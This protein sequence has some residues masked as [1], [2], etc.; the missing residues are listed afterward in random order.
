MARTVYVPEAGGALNFADGTTDQQIVDYVR[1]KYAP[2]PAPAP[3]EA[4]IGAL[5]SGFYGSLG[6]VE[7]AGGKA[8]QGLGLDAL[9]SDLFDRARAN[10]EYA[11]K[12]VPDVANISDIQGVGDVA[13]FAGS[14]IAQSAP[15]TAL[16][17]AGA[18]A[19]AATGASIGTAF[20]PGPGTAVGGV[21]GGIIGGAIASLPSFVGG[22]V[23]AQ[24]REQGISLE[25]TSGYA[26]TVGAVAQAPLDAAFDTLIARKFPGAGAALDV[27][28]KGFFKEVANTAWKGAG[29]EALTEPAQQAIEIAQANPLKLLEFGPDVQNELLNA[30]AGGALAGGIIGGAAVP[31]SRAVEGYAAGKQQEQGKQIQRDYMADAMRG[32]QMK[33][34]AEINAGIESLSAQPIL[35]AL[36]LRKVRVEPTPANGLTD[37]IERFQISDPK[38]TTIAEFSDAVNAT[39]AVNQYSKIAGKKINL[40]NIDTGAR[41]PTSVAP[42]KPVAAD[43]QNINPVLEPGTIDV[44]PK[45]P[46]MPKA[47]ASAIK[48]ANLASKLQPID[49]AEIPYDS[50][51]WD[52][53]KKTR[54]P[55]S[56]KSKIIDYGGRK[57]VVVSVN[58]VKVPFYLSSGLAGKTNVPSGKWYP[59]FGIGTDGWINKTSQ[60]EIA[61]YYGDEDLRRVSETLDATVGDIRNDQT[62]PR[63]GLSGNHISFINSGLDPSENESPDTLEKVTRNIKST[64]DKVRANKPVPAPVEPAIET[65]SD[66]ASEAPIGSVEPTGLS[67]EPVVAIPEVQPQT[68]VAGTEVDLEAAAPVMNE[69]EQ[70]AVRKVVGER[71]QKITEGV[72]A[73]LARYNLKDVQTKF[74]PAFMD[75]M[76]RPKAQEGSE[77]ISGGKSIVTLATDIYDPSLTTEEMVSK[78]IDTLNHESIHS[79]FDLGLIRPSERQVLFNAVSNAKVPGKKYTYLDYAKLVY[80]PK[81]PGLEIYEN[82]EL[83]IEEAVAEMFRDWRNRGTGATAN[84]RGLF[85]RVI[86]ALRHMFNVMRRNNYEDI[87]TQV[88]KGEVGLR[89]R[90]TQERAD[91]QSS[92]RK[93]I[94]PEM[95]KLSVAP[96]YPY[97]QRVPQVNASDTNRVIEE[98]EY[99]AIVTKIDKIF[100]SRIFSYIP[101]RYKPSEDSITEFMQ[102]WADKILPVG[103]MIDFVKQNGGTVTDA[104]DTYQKAQLSVSITSENLGARETNLYKPL[105][106]FMKENGIS[107]GEIGRYVYAL[108]AEERN[109]RIRAITEPKLDDNGNPI[110]FDP[111]FGSGMSDADARKI[112]KD[113]ESGP[114]ASQLA[115]AEQMVRQI[116]D[117]TNQLRLDSGLSPDYETIPITIQTEDGRTVTLA[118]YKKYV[119]LRG[120]ADESALDGDMA[121]EFKARIG[122]GFK[123]KGREDMRAFGRT[124]EASYE[125]IL[126]HIVLQNKEA[127]VRAEKNKVGQS[128]L[129]LIETNPEILENYGVEIMTAKTKPMRKYVNSRGV[130]KTM[131]DPMYKNSNDVFVVKKDG[132]EIPIKIDNRLLQKALIV[133]KSIDPS[134]NGKFIQFLGKFNRIMAAANTVYNP[135]FALI[136]FPRDLQQ[137]MLNFTQYDI[138]GV[139]MKILKDAGPAAWNVWKILRDPK[140]QNDWSDVYAQFKSDGG[141]TS[142]FYGAFSLEE[143]IR[144]LERMS[145]DPSNSPA[146]RAKEAILWVGKYL[147]DYNGAFE[148][149]IRLSVYKNLLD[150]NV[151]RQKAAFIAKNITVNFDQ[152]GEN[153]P[154]MNSL[155]LFYNASVQ[156]TMTLLTAAARSKKVRK[157]LMGLVFFGFMQDLINSS[158]SQDGDDEEPLYDKLPDYKLEN[159]IILMDPFGFTDKGYI[160]IPLG[161]G[162]NA[163]VNLG[164]A[165]S[166]SIRGGYTTGEAASSIGST[167]VDAFNPVGGTES[168]LNFIVP[169]SLD[170]VVALWGN[171]DYSGRK[172][173]PTAFPG[174][175]PKADSQTYF[176]STSP[177]AISVAQFLNKATGGSEYIPGYV[178]IYPDAI[179]Y[180]YDYILGAAGATA[181]RVVDT[182]MNDVPKV[183]QGD[184]SNIEMNNI[185]IFRKVY[186]NVSERMSFEDYFNKVNHV[187]MRGEELKYAIKEGDP[188]RVKQVRAKFADELKIYPAIKALANRRNKL[189][190]ELRKVRENTKMPPEQKRRRQDVLQKQIEDITKRVDLLYGKQIGSKYPG[191]FS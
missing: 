82:P 46:K 35:G 136:N 118:P 181:R 109:A 151:S 157:A 87:F 34:S 174:S 184:W 83:V 17:V 137:A 146:S 114:R 15:E 153:G 143:Q 142:G 53:I 101:D 47:M 127:V 148:N 121:E 171:M 80:D 173:Y 88:E 74:V 55:L 31:V 105:T 52:D 73:A 182:A 25:D 30:A 108:H 19:G 29:T 122:Q 154:L 144:K 3:Q 107:R 36:K 1:S 65:I 76:N 160:A 140:A 190:S 147:E 177:A 84:T 178:S 133:N 158:M 26:A 129:S 56:G 150:V 131:V 77:V 9:A 14:T 24:A 10:E 6:R 189:A 167:F 33:K 50:S 72:Q 54:T 94:A 8:A 149:A 41:V 179:E 64:L 138:D 103:Q 172:I 95:P 111:A 117:D 100:K 180:V 91:E 106:D 32:Q 7:A 128:F 187:L 58:G 165:M 12:Y 166:R 11:A 124:S 176:S 43:F 120:F 102:K 44:K 66:P 159:N 132:V 169:S 126:P 21:I 71:K 28:R 170:P 69:A 145:M 141:S 104:L 62:I 60:Q 79:L 51:T 99:G 37:A 40:M 75:A 134:T 152:R 78:V 42:V 59:F 38:G 155:Y 115:R 18:Y 113:V 186:G 93:S 16:G 191:L 27:A 119:P 175:I 86:D 67:A 156:G 92:E 81:K 49:A 85:N 2:A 48:N 168:L 23:Q 57:M 110:P 90:L 162:A 139:K 112:I 98:L 61:N 183:L 116:I 96:V 22:N 161:Y 13:S 130:V 45:P 164:R 163:F 123:I 185:P 97:G 125:D 68:T 188:T 89:E 20:F 135:E 4:G 39:D 63:V 70:Q 5:E